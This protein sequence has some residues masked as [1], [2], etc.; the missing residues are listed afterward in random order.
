MLQI[1]NL[2]V[3]VEKKKII[4]NLNLELP[5]G[6]KVAVMG[7]NGSGKSTLSNIIAGKQ[8]YEINEGEIL[9]NDENILELEPD[10]RAARGIYLAF[11][12]HFHGMI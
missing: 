6:K 7:P 9:Y 2:T 1:K 10:E 4:N 11:Q 3:T 12:Y 8:G 5:L